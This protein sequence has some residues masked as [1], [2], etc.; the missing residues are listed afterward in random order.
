[1][2]RFPLQHLGDCDMR[3]DPTPCERIVVYAGL[4]VLCAA[5]W[6]GILWGMVKLCEK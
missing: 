5:V 3:D 2:T 1:M 4:L 6:A